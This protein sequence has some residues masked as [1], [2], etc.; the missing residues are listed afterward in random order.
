MFGLIPKRKIVTRFF[1]HQ[2][3]SPWFFYDF[4]SKIVFVQI[5]Y[6][7]SLPSVLHVWIVKRHENLMKTSL[8]TQET[9][10]KSDV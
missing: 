3:Y 1:G 8:K 6:G 5:V 9:Q 2:G 10:Y 4:G 7:D